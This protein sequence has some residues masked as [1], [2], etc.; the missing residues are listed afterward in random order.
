MRVLTID[1]ASDTQWQNRTAG[2]FSDNNPERT[3]IS[4]SKPVN[5]I[6]LMSVKRFQIVQ[7]L[8]GQGTRSVEA[9]AAKLGR[10]RLMVERDL[11]ILLE[12]EVIERDRAHRYYFEFAAIRIVLQFPLPGDEDESCSRGIT[13]SRQS[14]RSRP[15]NCGRR[16]FRRSR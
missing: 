16:P 12:S 6:R 3:Y 2:F 5:I 1:V 9:I 4:F 7:L 10:N 11:E 8:M 15:G 13:G 14:R